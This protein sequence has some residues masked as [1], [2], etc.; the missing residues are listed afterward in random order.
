MTPAGDI[1]LRPAAPVDRPFLFQVYASTRVDELSLVDWDADQRQAFLE[2]QY[3]AQDETYHARYPDGDFLVVCSDERPIGRLYIGRLE[4]EVR[5]VDITLL[6][7][8]RGQ[9]IGTRLIQGVM[10]D[11]QETGGRVTLYVEAFNPAYR[12]YERLGFER[13]GEHGIYQLMEW[14]PAPRRPVS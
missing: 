1:R 5:I 11:A 9:G 6:P 13:I 3:S 10:A 2:Q 8:H 12:L 7:E 4:T 14:R